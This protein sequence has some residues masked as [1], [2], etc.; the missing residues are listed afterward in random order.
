MT[1]CQQWWRAFARRITFAE[2]FGYSGAS[3]DRAVTAVA[4][5]AAWPTIITLQDGRILLAYTH[6]NVHHDAT[7]G[8]A[9]ARVSSDNGATWGSEFTI[10]DDPSVWTTIQGIM[11]TSSGRIIASCWKDTGSGSATG[12]ALLLTA[13]PS[14]LTDWSAPVDVNSVVGRDAAYCSGSAL[15][16]SSGR[17]LQPIECFDS[18]P[19]STVLEAS[20]VLLRSDDDG[21]TWEFHSVAAEFAAG[22][23]DFDPAFNESGILQITGGPSHLMMVHRRGEA[24]PMSKSHST[25]G[26]LT[27]T[28]PSF[29]FNGHGAA[30]INR[31]PNGDIMCGTRRISDGGASIF[32]TRDDGATWVEE[33]ILCLHADETEYVSACNLDN[34]TLLV[35]YGFQ[36]IPGGTNSNIRVLNLRRLP[37]DFKGWTTAGGTAVIQNYG[38]F[39]YTL[40]GN[41]QV[42]SDVFRDASGSRYCEFLITSKDKNVICGIVKSAANGAV[43]PGFDSNGYG[44]YVNDGTK[45]NGS[46]TVAFASGANVGDIVGLWLDAGSLKVYVNGVLLGTAFTGLT[47]L[48]T[49]AF[50]PGT[51]A[52]GQRGAYINMGSIPFLYPQAGDPNWL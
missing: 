32:V 30:K 3:R 34:D 29:A 48:F 33:V 15:Q 9:V 44:Y 41:G 38:S 5:Y 35:A 26:G 2:S 18:P 46:G 47:G 17:I 20:C 31:A 39:G 49:P 43:F 10:Y 11:Q 12:H 27:W 6:G 50:G 14:D 37:G 51:S 40:D 22:D 4:D 24:G 45:L 1:A 52:A 25:D 13:D 21:D 7:S 28:A 42:R 8:V 23:P 19:Y 16:L 36:P